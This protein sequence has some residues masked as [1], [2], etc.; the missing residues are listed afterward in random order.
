MAPP[1]AGT[2]ALT[3]IAPVS[4]VIVPLSSVPD[5]A[6]AERLVGDGIAIDPVSDLIVAPCSGVVLQLH[7]AGHAVTIGTAGG[8]EVLIHVG[9]DTVML[10]GRGFAPRARPGDRVRPG[11]PLLSF[12]ADLVATQARSLLTEMVVTTMEG[13]T[14][15]KPRT[16]VVTAGRDV[17]LEVWQ[18][19][20]TV[21]AAVAAD[22]ADTVASEPIVIS[23]P[24]GLHARPAAVIAARARQFRSAVRLARGER[25]ANAKSLTSLMALEVA[26]GDVVVIEASG[27][28]ASQAVAVLSRVVAE[29]ARDA[30][31]AEPAT[32]VSVPAGRTGAGA[33]G[34][35]ADPNRLTGVPASPGVALGQIFQ[36]RQHEAPVV[37][38]AA[39]PLRERREL[40]HALAEAHTQLDTL[41]QRLA[42]GADADKAA[43]FAAHKELLEDPDL[44]DAAVDA[45]Q[46]G[47]SAAFAWQQAFRAQADRLS[48]LSTEMLAARA[49]DI[50]DVGRRVLRILTG[51]ADAPPQWPADA[52]VIAED[53]T[54]SD[55]ASLDRR[56]VRGVCTTGGSSTSHA[57]ILARALDLPAVAAID[58]RALELAAGT[59]AMIDG[60][61]GIL[62]IDPSDDEQAWVAARQE[63]VVGRR[64]AELASTQEPAVTTDGHRV[65][66]VCNIGDLAE[67][68]QVLPS[69]GEGVGL[70]RTEFLFLDRQE[71]PSEDEQTRIYEDIVRALGPERLVAV[72][73]LD[74]GG[75]KPLPY[76][77]MAPEQNPFLGERGIRMLLNRPGV[78]RT[79]LRAIVR[80]SAAGRL[81]VMFPM[82][83]TMEEWA[84]AR[85]LC[86]DVLLELG[87]PPIPI[88]IMVETPAAAL[89]ADLFA[90]DTDFFSI[91]TNDLT[92]YTLAMDRTHPR[93][94]PALDGLHP[95]VLRLVNQTVQGARA[96]RRRVGVCG[97]LAGDPQAVP[98]LIG[99][100]VDELSVS[101]PAV[102]AVKAL[103]RRLRLS[104]C[105]DVAARALA[106][107]TASEVRALIPGE[108]D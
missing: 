62:Q 47:A 80:A 86:E 18:S 76:L 100:G 25:R 82:V 14:L 87:A 35:S 36:W 85:A 26:A 32:R 78:L 17:V 20:A 21:D 31:P 68:R 57:A 81:C 34:V 54:P 75:D 84:A 15:G 10:K 91:G 28:D 11:D 73:T 79:Q 6:F 60:S 16:G 38:R 37:E 27:E 103:I 52:I 89:L 108:E 51:V 44:L 98:I 30:A 46:G 70:L 92:Q 95:A 90:R 8:L 88:G 50:R 33:A 67:A 58:P 69:G 94:A 29:E 102:P 42:T 24:T 41:Q 7:S 3:L 53:L 66:V 43:I 5:P 12:D 105:R 19:I 63:R 40:D 23:N 77:P 4:G 45:I 71:P 96:R 97:S 56:R 55:T 104:S 2:A 99:L 72:R 74:V 1:T 83:A 48:R 49:G 107:G 106:A 93:L 65:E 61:R 64:A 13:V 22:G 9:L 39:D 101:V 59:P